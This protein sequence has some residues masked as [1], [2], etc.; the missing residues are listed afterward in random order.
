[1]ELDV[2]LLKV[3]ELKPDVLPVVEEDANV[4]D[5][6]LPVE[7]VLEETVLLPAVVVELAEV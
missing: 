6:E 5:V 2:L 1:M 7:L 4:V 3:S